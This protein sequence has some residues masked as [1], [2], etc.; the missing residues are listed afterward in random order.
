MRRVPFGGCLDAIF[1]AA[2]DGVPERVRTGPMPAH[3][4]W[5]AKAMGN[6]YFLVSSDTHTVA[7]HGSRAGMIRFFEPSFGMVSG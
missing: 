6:R 5:L 1:S 3:A 7:A 2:R 4:P